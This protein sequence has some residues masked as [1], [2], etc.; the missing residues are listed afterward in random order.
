MRAIVM[1]PVS[2][3]AFSASAPTT[4]RTNMVDGSLSPNRCSTPEQVPFR[5]LE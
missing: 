3:D 1:T 4:N 2:H 5:S